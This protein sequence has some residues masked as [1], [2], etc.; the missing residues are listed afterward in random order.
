MQLFTILKHDDIDQFLVVMNT[1]DHTQLY[2]QY[3]TTVDF[4]DGGIMRYA[5]RAGCRRI[6]KLLYQS[7]PDKVWSSMWTLGVFESGNDSNVRFW[8]NLVEPILLLDDL[9]VLKATVVLHTFQM[10]KSK[11]FLDWL[12]RT[13]LAYLDYLY[14]T[15]FN[16]YRSFLQQRKA[17][18]QALEYDKMLQHSTSIIEALQDEL[19]EAHSVIETLKKPTRPPIIRLS[20]RSK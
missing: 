2:V 5:C 3:I 7:L 12:E 13:D 1:F 17:V 18:Q 11:A 8:L 19:Y 4:T 20:A 6:M 14:E 10:V 9:Y 16:P 15:T